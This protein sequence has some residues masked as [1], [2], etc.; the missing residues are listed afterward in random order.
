MARGPVH[1]P[2]WISKVWM[3]VCMSVPQR[4]YTLPMISLTSLT[5]GVRD[6]IPTYNTH[7]SCPAW[8][9][10]GAMVKPHCHAAPSLGS[11]KNR[12]P[13]EVYFALWLFLRFFL[14]F[15]PL[16][17]SFWCETRGS[18]RPPAPSSRMLSVNR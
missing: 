12:F 1:A 15:F 3:Y 6:F 13:L 11:V 16:H 8:E 7:E 9:T 4:S 5:H 2:H 17:G 10:Q 18:S 14:R